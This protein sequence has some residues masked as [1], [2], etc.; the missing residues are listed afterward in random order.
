MVRRCVEDGTG[1]RRSLLVRS[2]PFLDSLYEYCY[3]SF[4]I[5]IEFDK[6]DF[7]PCSFDESS[8]LDYHARARGEYECLCVAVTVLAFVA[9]ALLVRRA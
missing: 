1:E 2:Y 7:L 9:Y 8:F 6:H 4:P 5:M 3:L